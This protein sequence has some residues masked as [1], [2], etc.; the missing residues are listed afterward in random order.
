M[1]FRQDSASDC[2]GPPGRREFMQVGALALGG[3]TLPEVLAGRAARAAAGNSS[4]R[5]SVIMLYQHGGAS[6][7]ETYDLKPEAPT[8]TRSQFAPISTNVPGLDICEHFP[9]QAK[10][11]DK[12]SIIRSLHHDMSSHSDGGIMVLTGKSPLVADPTSLGL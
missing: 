5:T 1:S 4:K 10:L 7:L 3:L 8:A 9:L 11:A 2:P 12:F 6:Q